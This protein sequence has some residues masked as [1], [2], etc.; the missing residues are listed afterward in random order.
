MSKSS[1]VSEVAKCQIGEVTVLL[2]L[3]CKNRVSCKIG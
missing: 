2:A 3:M 1:H